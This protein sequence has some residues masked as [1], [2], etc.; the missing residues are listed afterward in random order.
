MDNEISEMARRCY[1]YGR[2][3]APYWFIGP[4]Q[5]QP[6]E[7]NDDLRIRYDAWRHCGGGE[8]SD[9]RVFHD[10]LNL[11]MGRT[12]HLWHQKEPKL[13]TTWRRLMLV[14]MGFLARPTD[15]DSLK[16]YQRDRLGSLSGE[17][18]VIELSGLPAHS[19]MTP[20]DR[21]PFLRER[22]TVISERMCACK[23]AWVVIYGVGTKKAWER[24]GGCSPDDLRQSQS[25]ILEFTPHPSRPSRPAAYWVARGKRLRQVAT[26]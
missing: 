6:R 17:T 25:T 13:Q 7:E 4:E 10:A 18:C 14:L 23:P 12:L 2:W 24:G 15:E 1:G 22:I 21:D 26:T 9:C 5:G 16:A 11:R 20:R 3:E 19:F 8:L